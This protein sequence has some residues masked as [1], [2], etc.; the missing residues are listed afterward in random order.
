MGRRKTANSIRPF[1]Q[2][3]PSI[4]TRLPTYFRTREFFLI[5]HLNTFDSKVFL[6][7]EIMDFEIVPFIKVVHI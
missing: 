5:A 7:L 2:N 3:Q 1:F 6:T 4:H